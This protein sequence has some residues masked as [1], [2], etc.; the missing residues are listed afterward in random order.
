[1]LTH[2]LITVMCLAIYATVGLSLEDLR[3]SLAVGKFPDEGGVLSEDRGG[4]WS[5]IRP[6]SQERAPE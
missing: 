4:A 2:A 1:M 3:Y 5:Y 6:D